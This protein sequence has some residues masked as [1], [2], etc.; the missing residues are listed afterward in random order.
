MLL[1]NHALLRDMLC[2]VI[3][4]SCRV[5]ASVHCDASNKLPSLHEDAEGR[6][7]QLPALSSFSS[8]PDRFWVTLHSLS[9]ESGM[10]CTITCRCCNVQHR[11]VFLACASATGALQARPQQDVW[12][13]Q[14]LL[15]PCRTGLGRGPAMR[16]RKW[17]P[18]VLVLVTPRKRRRQAAM[19][20]GSAPFMPAHLMHAA[21]CPQQAVPCSRAACRGPGDGAQL[22]PTSLLLHVPGLHEALHV[23]YAPWRVVWVEIHMEVVQPGLC[24]PCHSCCGSGVSRIDHQHSAPLHNSQQVIL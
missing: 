13:G 7:S 14:A 22:C 19:P 8:L 2:S 4:L 12:H 5:R 21:D 9:R 11:Q 24:R 23:S 20:Q 6:T 15:V 1:S 18:A 10:A 3:M 16:Q 17:S